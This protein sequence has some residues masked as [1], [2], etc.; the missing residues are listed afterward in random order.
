MKRFCQRCRI[1]RAVYWTRPGSAR[2]CAPCLVEV[3]QNKQTAAQR[4]SQ[5]RRKLNRKRRI[6]DVTAWVDNYKAQLG[7]W[8]CG[9]SDP[10]CL[11]C[12]H[13]DPSAKEA[14]IATLIK[15][16]PDLEVIRKELAKCIVICSNCQRKHHKQQRDR[17]VEEMRASLPALGKED[18]PRPVKAR[19]QPDRPPGFA[20][21]MAELRQKCFP[22]P[23]P[24]PPPQQLVGTRETESTLDV[25]DDQ[26]HQDPES[27]FET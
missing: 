6:A 14:T 18:F 15:Q 8:F 20:E 16:R 10:S 13:E 2:Y 24:A 17:D 7:C 23:L 5:L 27:G 21:V 4:A 12:H 9:E 19:S 26:D 11:D 22:G 3:A 1:F 25:V